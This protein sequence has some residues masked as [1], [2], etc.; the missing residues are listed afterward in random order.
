M[1]SSFEVKLSSFLHQKGRRFS[2]QY[3]KDMG[4]SKCQ[5]RA[6]HCVYWPGINSDIKHLVKA[7]PT[8]QHHQPQEPWQLLQPTLA[9]DHPWQLLGTDY[10]CFDRSEYLVVTDY[11]SK[12]PIIRRIPV[13]QCNASKTISVLKEL[14]AE[15]GILEIPHTDNGSQ[16]ANALFTK[17]AT[18]W[19]FDHNTSSPRNPR[20][21]GQ[22]EA[23]I[24]TIKGLL[25]YA[26]WSGQ[27]PHQWLWRSTACF[28]KVWQLAKYWNSLAYSALVVICI[29]LQDVCLLTGFQI[30]VYILKIGF[31]LSHL[32]GLYNF[33]TVDIKCNILE[34]D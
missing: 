27:D 12:M 13:S 16:F 25:T 31:N 21:N 32:T 11:F 19:K 28:P 24:K 20:S 26:K 14:F 23:A 1:A 10:F 29:Q 3:M 6:R 15:H 7:C 34:M 2:K 17:F 33:L 4:I 22:T 5:N 9:P 18:N 30:C 8:C